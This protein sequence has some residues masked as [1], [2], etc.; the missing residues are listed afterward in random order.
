VEYQGISSKRFERCV[1]APTNC[2]KRLLHVNKS[3]KVANH[4]GFFGPQEVA[5]NGNFFVTLIRLEPYLEV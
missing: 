4:S 1:A 2:H 3:E 5:G